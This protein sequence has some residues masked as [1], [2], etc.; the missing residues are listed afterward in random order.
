MEGRNNK[1]T[2]ETESWTRVCR[3]H[4]AVSTWTLLSV[5]SSARNKRN[6][7]NLL[8]PLLSNIPLRLPSALA[9]LTRWSVYLHVISYPISRLLSDWPFQPIPPMIPQC[10]LYGWSLNLAGGLQASR[11]VVEELASQPQARLKIFL[12][13]AR[14]PV[15]V[16]SSTRIRTSLLLSLLTPDALFLSFQSTICVCLSKSWKM[17]TRSKQSCHNSSKPFVLFLFPPLGVYPFLVHFYFSV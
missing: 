7:W 12:G 10:F 15:V 5:D 9:R 17:L 16:Y 4:A 11:S 2:G 6:P 3:H 8:S 1:N 14:A 13:R